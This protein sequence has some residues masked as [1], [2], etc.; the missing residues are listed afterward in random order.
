MSKAARRSAWALSRAAAAQG[1]LPAGHG[2]AEARVE[3]ME[4]VTVSRQRR[5]M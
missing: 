4:E 3:G 2:A 1:V 5:R